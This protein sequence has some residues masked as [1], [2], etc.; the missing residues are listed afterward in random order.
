[1]DIRTGYDNINY[2]SAGESVRTQINDLHSFFEVTTNP[3]I[4]IAKIPSFWSRGNV[5]NINNYA[6]ETSSSARIRSSKIYLDKDYIFDIECDEPYE[7]YT[8]IVKDDD[9]IVTNYG[10]KPKQI[11]L[12]SYNGNTNIDA[13]D[14]PSRIYRH[15]I[16]NYIRFVIR[17]SD[18]SNIDLSCL[19][20]VHI[21]KKTTFSG[22]LTTDS[23]IA[24]V[25]GY[26]D[27]SIYFEDFN[28]NSYGNSCT[29]F[30]PPS[31]IY[32][33]GEVNETINKQL[34]YDTFESVVSQKGVQNTICI[35]HN[36][37]LYY[38]LSSKTLGIKHLNSFNFRDPMIIQLLYVAKGAFSEGVV[39]GKLQWVYNEYL[40]T[41]KI[42]NFVCIS[43]LY[44]VVFNIGTLNMDNGSII[45]TGGTSTKRVYS[46]FIKVG[47]GTK[48]RRFD[49]SIR[50]LYYTYDNSNKNVITKIGWSE[51]IELTIPTDCYIRILLKKT[52]ESEITDS[53]INDIVSKEYINIKPWTET[54]EL[55]V[56]TNPLVPNYY[57]NQLSDA[58][59]SIIQNHFN[60]GSHG[61][62]FIFI[63]DLHWQS[64][65]K[66]SPILVKDIIDNTPINKILIGGDLIGGSTD[67]T[68]EIKRMYDCVSSYNKIADTYITY[69]NHDSNRIGTTE[70]TDRFNKSQ[71]YSLTQSFLQNNN[72]NYGYPLVYCDSSTGQC[73]YY[74]FD[75]IG[76][77]TRF[78]CLDS[79]QGSTMS[80]AQNTWLTSILNN[81]PDNYHFIIFAHILYD[82]STSWHVGIEPSELR[83]SNFLISLESI[84]DTFNANNNTKK[85]EAI[86]GGHVH[87]DCDF[88]TPGG[89][90][91][92]ITDTDSS[93][94]FMTYIDEDSGDAV[95]NYSAGTITECAFDAVN[96]NYATKTIKC[97]RIGR[98]ENRTISYDTTT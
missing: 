52:D 50:H 58:K 7:V 81:A 38:D 2:Q 72:V 3:K 30:I 8:Y 53:E 10:W 59:D 4:D 73:L 16:T 32:L 55:D 94:T 6:H 67:K 27:D 84:V 85:V 65:R 13:I 33:R 71:V 22:T 25:S 5:A 92:I 70:E 87:I 17:K 57:N 91:I 68:T 56:N 96:I 15:D 89:I 47:V 54:R 45:L 34:F 78:I 18:N 93:Q 26:T 79:D 51:D 39:G 88:K 12:G 74:Y 64:N 19:E 14:K 62:N 35:P 42:N 69:G 23:V 98:G 36:N 75:D 29:Y 1:M 43:D 41:K 77:N 97:I 49:N 37:I 86:F 66:I 60:T 9:K 61:T 11:L 20:H 95:K 21:I 44:S 31:D 82:T 48:L 40:L 63:T 76:T 24:T 46:N 28:G 90:P 83:K 80:T